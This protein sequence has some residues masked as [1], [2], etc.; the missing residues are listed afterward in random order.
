MNEIIK[1][2]LD[3]CGGQKKLANFCKVKQPTVHRWLKG[4]GINGK[5][6][7][8]I[9]KASNGKVTETDILRSLSE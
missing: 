4:G 7:H 2:V 9:A 5:Y 3:E 6:I 8:L 1:R